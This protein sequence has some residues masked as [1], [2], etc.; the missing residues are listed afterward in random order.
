MKRRLAAAAALAALASCGEISAF[1][2]DS[3]EDCAAGNRGGV[4]TIYRFCAFDD[5]SCPFDLRYHAS[6]GVLGGVCVGDEESVGF[7]PPPQC[8]SELCGDGL[9]GDCRGD[10]DVD[11]VCPAGDSP[12]APRP[13]AGWQFANI[14]YARNDY[15]PSCGGIGGR[16]V[17][18]QL[19][20]AD[21]ARLYVDTY[22]TDFRAILAVHQGPCSALGPELAC[23]EYACSEQFQMWTGLLEAGSHCVIVDQAD[24]DEAAFGSWNLIVRSTTGAPVP[25]GYIGL[26][27]GDTC[28]T[29]D[30]LQ[31][32][33]SPAGGPDQA[34][35]VT[36]CEP[37]QLRFSTCVS[38]PAFTGTVQAWNQYY[39]ELGC[40]AGCPGVTID[41]DEPGAL[42]LLAE[43]PDGASC[44]P[45]AAE[46][47]VR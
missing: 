1:Y 11:P 18:F 28:A 30:L 10:A 20:L 24:A 14:R 8:G 17:F 34:W 46:L 27:G 9:D 41:L 38:Q 39:G 32:S 47:A 16:D 29:G 23:V 37:L 26:L 36:S 42:W 13:L 44:G 15:G 7:E 45:I 3:D 22:G 21:P 40:G 2:C 6:A 33:C 31:A 25:E 35:L 19:D 43:A 5:P 12:L 4:C